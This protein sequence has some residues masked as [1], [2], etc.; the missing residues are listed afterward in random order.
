MIII[1]YLSVFLA[2]AIAM[3]GVAYLT[4]RYVMHGFGWALHRDHHQ[5]SGRGLQ[6]NDLYA[7]FFA[8]PAIV[9]IALGVLNRQPLLTWAGA[10]ITLYGVGYELFHDIMFHRRIRGVRIPAST[11]YLKRIVNAHRV[12]HRHN[13]KEDATSFGFLYANPKYNT[14]P[15]SRRQAS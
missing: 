5:P 1:L 14:I 2:L 8:I 12:H 6:W 4:H 15:E 11:P 7:A 9:L 3:E 10:G 13:G